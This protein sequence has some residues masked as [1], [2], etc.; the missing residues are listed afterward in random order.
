[1]N[2]PGWLKRMPYRYRRCGRTLDLG[3]VVE[4]G[5]RG[6]WLPRFVGEGHGEHGGSDGDEG[7]NDVCGA[8]AL[9]IIGVH[10]ML[11]VFVV[12]R[13]VFVVVAI[14]PAPGVMS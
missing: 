1:M 6:F 8:E 2:L 3:L 9:S 5:Q 7:Q 12:A 13:P 10:S 11:R 14:A 4:D